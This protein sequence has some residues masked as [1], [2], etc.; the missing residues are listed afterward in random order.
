MRAFLAIGLTVAALAFALAILAPA[1]LVDSRVGAMTA[2]RVRVTHAAGTVWNGSG[3]IS[4]P[5]AEL[6]LPVV[7]HVERLPLLWAEIHGTLSEQGNTPAVFDIGRD[8]YDVRNL[9]LSLPA[10]ALLRAFG[11][12][13]MI[14]DAGGR[15]DI[16]VGRLSKQHDALDGQVEARWLDASL[17]G[18]RPDARIALGDV[19]IE[20]AGS[21][22]K[23]VG[24]IAN[25]GG[26][27]DIAGSIAVTA[28]GDT[29]IDA[30]IRP[31]DGLDVERS[32]AIAAV[33]SMIGRADGT[34][35]YRVAWT[36]AP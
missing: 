3:D 2:G 12:P 29:G 10:N 14:A 8:R 36:I 9:T 26:S 18:P 1:T 21:G 4:V 34:G 5:A 7:W 17:P 33:L 19:R 28:S 22:A 25:A 15:V 6:R 35:A 20:G 30:L 13:A 24:T 31:R 16:H 27:V 11:A 23:L 32:N